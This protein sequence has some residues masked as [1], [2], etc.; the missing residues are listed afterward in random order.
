MSIVKETEQKC[1]N[2]GKTA[3]INI[4]Q[5]WIRFT[6]NK[7]TGNWDNIDIY[8]VDSNEFYCEECWDEE[9]KING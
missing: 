6:W 1:K 9:Q 2:C 3:E 5:A 4:Q 7:I 8:A